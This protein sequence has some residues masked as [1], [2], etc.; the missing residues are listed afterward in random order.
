MEIRKSMLGVHISEE[1]AK[2]LATK[3]NFSG[4]EIENIA[5]KRAIDYI[6]EGV[7]PLIEKL[8]GY[9]ENELLKK[10]NRVKVEF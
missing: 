1:D 4:G 10:K 9:C 3:Y 7:N 5:R 6:I 2:E 8:K